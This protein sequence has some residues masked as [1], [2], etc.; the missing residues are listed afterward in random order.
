M[1]E[2]PVIIADDDMG[3]RLL[4]S[5][6]IEKAEGF[7]LI[8][9]AENGLELM[10]LVEEHRPQ[11]VFLDVE[12][13]GLTGVECAKR[14]Q[15]MDPATVLIFATAHQQ[16]M[17]DAFEVYAFDYLMKPFKMDRV[18]QTLQRVRNR[19]SIR[20][21]KTMASAIARKAKAVTG[22]IMLQHKDG[23][24]IINMED[25]LLVQREDRST[26]LYVKGGARYVTN[27]TLAEVE[28]RLDKEILF[29]CHKSYIINLK[30][31]SDI[32]PYGRW[33]Y[34][35]SLKGTQLDALITHQKYEEL[36]ALFL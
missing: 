22:R 30:E 13:P 10:K 29:R 3:M 19:L 5:K 6:V 35:V 34:I 25:I 27:Q 36:E 20:S 2:I 31:I 33:T 17:G 14:I 11:V 7:T 24:S 12:M 9:Q 26:V 23:T 4:M 32:S 16:Y 8:G 21:E 1:K 18:F 28:G 15:D